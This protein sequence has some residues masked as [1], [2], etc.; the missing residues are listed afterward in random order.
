MGFVKDYQAGEAGMQFV[1]SLFENA[2]LS[3]SENKSKK[4]S[5]LKL[6][7]IRLNS[8]GGGDGILIE[9]KHDLKERWTGNIAIECFNPKSGKESGL[10]VTGSHLWV[11]VLTNPK[12]AWVAS[13]V[14][15]KQWVE[16]TKPLRIV[17]GAGDGNA[18]IKIYPNWQILG[19]VFHRMDNLSPPELVDVVRGLLS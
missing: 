1:A 18:T 10:S 6:W 4:L 8:S 15:L 19:E 11:V 9:T 5:I 13:V 7:D 3:P 12:S 14:N 16:K 2:G 17:E